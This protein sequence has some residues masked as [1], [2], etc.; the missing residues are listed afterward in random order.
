MFTTFVGPYYFLEV[1]GK[2][3]VTPGA[4]VF[5]VA[6]QRTINHDAAPNAMDHRNIHLPGTG[7][8]ARMVRDDTT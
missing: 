6:M 1:C 2:Q 8:F 3:R 4:P 7:L 5:G